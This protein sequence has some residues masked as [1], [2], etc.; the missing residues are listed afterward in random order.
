MEPKDNPTAGD[1]P[2][3][4][5]GTASDGLEAPS[6]R[7]KKR[8]F[9]RLLFLAIVFACGIAIGKWVDTEALLQGR[10]ALRHKTPREMSGKT[11]PAFPQEKPPSGERKPLYWVD[12]M[13]PSHKSDKPGK[14]PDGMDL[15][16]VY[17]EE[18]APSESL[19]PGSVQIKPR[20]QQLI[21][22]QYGEVAEGP[23]TKTI[24]AVGMLASDETKIAHIH[25][26]FEGW[27]DETYI[28]FV[29]MLVEKGQ[30]LLSI[31]SP[32]LYSTQQELLLAKKSKETLADNEFKEI[33][34]GAVSLYQATRARLKLWDIPD[35]EIDAIEKRGSPMRSLKLYS[36][37][38]GF[39]QVRNAFP[40][41]RVTPDTELYT[42]VDLSNIWVFAEIYEY[43][44]PMVQVG[45]Q[46]KMSLSYH[47]GE[48]FT[49]KITYIYP[50]LNAETRTLKV[51]LEFPNK[52]YR[53][54]PDMYASVVVEKDLGVRI[55]VPAS[56]VLDSGT[57]QIVFVAL[58]NGYFEPRTV[59]TGPRV[60]GR[61]IIQK[62]LKPGEKIVTS[63]TFLVDSESKLKSAVGAMGEHVHGGVAPGAE[64]EKKPSAPSLSKEAPTTPVDHLRHPRPP[65]PMSQPDHS[66]HQAPS[67][68]VAQPDHSGHPMPSMNGEAHD[69]QNH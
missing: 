24:R 58:D 37:I 21:G 69:Q 65:E 3:P 15:V 26:K 4:A 50:R 44:L 33:A 67:P 36:P 1:N 57:E 68:P 18:G 43:E 14:A 35:R 31:Y 61:Y 46:A 22:V 40:G 45:Q 17:A 55:S 53:L 47:P 66:Q 5:G 9:G 29:G 62:G 11:V 25:T 60:E 13:N 34:S 52:N 48:T 39:V 8:W 10:L 28:D 12:P 51:R 42:V 56:A 41:L 64:E 59:E 23:V 2:Q 32:D 20:R 6:P 63:G 19:P 54:K 27:I 7:I 38:K 49:G 16:P 30:P